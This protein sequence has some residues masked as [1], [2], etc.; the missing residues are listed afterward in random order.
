V[1]IL[2]WK[3]TK[4]PINDIVAEDIDD[5][6]DSDITILQTVMEK[7]SYNNFV[8][9][10]RDQFS[11]SRKD[12]REFRR[13]LTEVNDNDEFETVC[14]H[15]IQYPPDL[16]DLVNLLF[17]ELAERDDQEIEIDHETDFTNLKIV[18]TNMNH[19]ILIKKFLD[20]FTLSAET[21]N[22]EI[23]MLKGMVKNGRRAT[24]AYVDRNF[25]DPGNFWLFIKHL[26][27]FLP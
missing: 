17:N 15:F 22:S 19:H 4:H 27:I 13:R 18:L 12:A 14:G 21:A 3:E 5:I 20:E 16:M 6:T 11:L 26:K 8:D 7:C 24:I 1:E 2:G 10:L 25:T 9:A 23:N